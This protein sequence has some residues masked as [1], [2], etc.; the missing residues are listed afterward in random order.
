MADETSKAATKDEGPAQAAPS[1]P[2]LPTP[3]QLGRARAARKA[4][5]EMGQVKVGTVAGLPA[6]WQ[7]A[8]LDPAL[9]EGRKAVLRAKWESLGWIKLDGL[10]HVAGYPL[11]IEVF[12][13]PEDQYAADREER[14]AK[15]HELARRGLVLF[16]PG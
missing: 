13:K 6:G 1:T 5:G 14:A 16:G 3:A 10:H 4:A 12:V 7:S 2:K 8:K 15:F 9:D 11:P